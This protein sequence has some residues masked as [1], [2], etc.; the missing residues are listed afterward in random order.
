MRS[1]VYEL[2]LTLFMCHFRF[3]LYVWRILQIRFLFF[4]AADNVFSWAASVSFNNR[5]LMFNPKYLI[6]ASGLI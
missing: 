1:E 4:F 2:P 5:D 6:A 3:V